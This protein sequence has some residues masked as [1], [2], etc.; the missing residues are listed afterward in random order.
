MNLTRII[1]VNI[2]TA[3]TSALVINWLDKKKVLPKK[4]SEK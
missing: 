1:L 4:E 2:V 3:I